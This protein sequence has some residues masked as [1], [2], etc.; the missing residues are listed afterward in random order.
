MWP[1]TLDYAKAQMMLEGSKPAIGMKQIVN[2][3]MEKLGRSA[4]DGR[5]AVIASPYVAQVAAII[6]RAGAGPL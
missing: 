1:S 3:T 6:C 2:S 5:A 4:R